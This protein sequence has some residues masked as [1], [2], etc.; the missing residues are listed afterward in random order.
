MSDLIPEVFI[1]D[2]AEFPDAVE[3]KRGSDARWYSHPGVLED[4]EQEIE[5][6]ETALATAIDERD[7][8]TTEVTELK[9]EVYRRDCD[10]E[11]LN[12]DIRRHF[13][14]GWDAAR[15]FEA[16]CG[17]EY[18]DALLIYLNDIDRAPKKPT[19]TT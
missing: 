5:R 13:E 6:L 4:A 7:R 3:I 14:A 18:D 17:E 12:E 2:D 9:E 1:P 8:A 16:N 10:I 11:G 15:D 19:D